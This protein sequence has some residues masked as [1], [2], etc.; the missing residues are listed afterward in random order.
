MAHPEDPSAAA[1]KPLWRRPLLALVA[2]QVMA[3]G[4]VF[5][6]MLLMFWAWGIRIPVWPLLAGQALLACGIGRLLGLGWGWGA[7]LLAF[8]FALYGGLIA[9]IPAWVWLGLTIVVALV[10]RNVLQDRVPLYLSNQTTWRAIE[11]LLPKDKPASIIDLGCGFG[12]VLHHLAACRS[13][14][15]LSGIESAPAVYIAAKIRCLFMRSS[16][17]S[18]IT[19]TYGNLWAL[20]LGPYDLVYCFLSPVPMKDLFV[21][22]KAEMKAGSILISNS[23]DVPD[24]VPDQVL[25][26]DDSRQTRLFI[27]R[28]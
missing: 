24:V 5:L 26:L 16:Q 7:L 11:G 23:F 22:V 12:G 18:P 10:Y 21:K 3:G 13:D 28:L 1:S 6:I 2:A 25:T 14:L 19:I 27:Y 8:P 15:S 17:L 20:D 4:L 9:P